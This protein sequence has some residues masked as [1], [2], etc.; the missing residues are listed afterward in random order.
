[1][2]LHHVHSC[3]NQHSEDY[4][5][6]LDYVGDLQLRTVILHKKVNEDPSTPLQNPCEE[7]EDPSTPLQ[8]PREEVEDP[9]REVNLT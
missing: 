5:F 9:G 3:H 4:I 2:S 7:V 1:M 6:H 8:K